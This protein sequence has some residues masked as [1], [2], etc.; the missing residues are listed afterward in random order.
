[1]VLNDWLLDK[2]SKITHQFIIQTSSI[3]IMKWNYIINIIF[4]CQK[5]QKYKIFQDCYKCVE[6][7]H[8][9]KCT[10][11]K[12]PYDIFFRGDEILIGNQPGTCERALYE[13]DLTYAKNLQSVVN[14][15]LNEICD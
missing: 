7:E 4:Y 15:Y 6:K 5:V 11:E 3:L 8:G 9:S 14:Y 13:C 12:A 1:M 10:T 2:C